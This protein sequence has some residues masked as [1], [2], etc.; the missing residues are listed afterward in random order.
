L[1]ESACIGRGLTAAGAL[2]QRPGFVHDAADQVRH[3]LRSPLTTISARIQLL[4]RVL[5]RSPALAEDERVRML[6]GITAIAA[7]VQILGAGIDTMNLPSCHGQAALANG[8][9]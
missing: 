6:A 2:F 3:D 1:L 5:R 4:A 8:G 9:R 7:E